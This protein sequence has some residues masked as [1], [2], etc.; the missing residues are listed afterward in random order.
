V[1]ATRQRKCTVFWLIRELQIYLNGFWSHRIRPKTAKDPQKVAGEK[2]DDAAFT[3]R[4]LTM[5]RCLR[6]FTSL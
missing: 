2:Y 5:P 3:I 4:A 1:R 6:A